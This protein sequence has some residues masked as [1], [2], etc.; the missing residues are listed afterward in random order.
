[1]DAAP[2]SLL[3]RGSRTSQHST[4]P[5]AIARL[6]LDAGANPNDFYMAGDSSY[7]ALVGAA[8]EG[9][10]DSPRQPYAAELFSLLLER[11]AEPY[12]IQVL[13]NTHFIGRHDL[14]AGADLR[15]HAR[16]R[17][18]G[19]TGTTR[20]WSM[21]DMGGYGSGAYFMLNTAI[22]NNDLTL[23]EW[24]LTHGAN[25]ELDHLAR[26]RS[27]SPQRPL[28]RPG[29]VCE[30]L[31]EMAESAAAP[32]R[33]RRATPLE[34]ARTRSSRPA[35]GWIA[36]AVHAHL[37]RTSRVSCTRTEAMFEAATPRSRPRSIALL[38]DLGVPVEIEDA[39]E[40]ARAAHAAGAQRV[41]C[42]RAS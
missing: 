11:G 9:E 39:D 41:A 29:A 35:C 8:G 36:T 13:Y 1:M 25:P 4:T 42:R 34:P 28:L 7:S 15:A 12:D 33:E 24:A 20:H 2:L 18:Q 22:S 32:R 37:A 30:G 26:I 40:A 5:S 16:D 3:T 27:S 21:F 19:A 31:D 17:A 14:V 6:L 38:L 10:Q 23:A